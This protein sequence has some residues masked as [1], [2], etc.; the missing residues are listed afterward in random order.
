MEPEILN[1]KGKKIGPEKGKLDLTDF[2]KLPNA[3]Q[4]AKALAGEKPLVILDVQNIAMRHGNKIF[5]CKG[6]Q[7]VMDYWLQNGHKVI[8]FLPDYLLDYDKVGEMKRL[9]VIILY[10]YIYMYIYI[11]IYRK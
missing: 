1:S 3:P 8:S 7:I 6:I 11:Y 10:I 2:A 5:S 4:F 9:K